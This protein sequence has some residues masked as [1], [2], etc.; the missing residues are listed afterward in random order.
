MAATTPPGPEEH[1][2]TAIVLPDIDRKTFDELRDR[3]PSLKLSEI[4]LPRIDKIEIPRI[5]KVG[6]DADKAIDKLLGRE[7]NPVWPWVA[8]GIALVAVVG[9]VAAFV[10]WGRRGS[11]NGSTYGSG[12]SGAETG[13]DLG[14]SDIYGSTTIS[15]GTTS[16]DSPTI[17]TQD[18][19]SAGSGLTAAESSLTTSLEGN[20]L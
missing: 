11:W 19:G 10:S 8:A 13:T 3:M 7:K 14:V 9:V 4:E 12:R 15:G 6:R 20:N 2:M 16:I 18:I 5:E 1:Q 17:D